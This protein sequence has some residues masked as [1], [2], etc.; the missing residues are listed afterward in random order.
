[1]L[2]AG[3]QA[4]SG[5]VNGW[6]ALAAATA[7]SLIPDLVWFHLGRAYGTRV[8]GFLCRL[9]L[10]PDSCSRRMQNLFSRFGLRGLLVAKFVPGLSTLAPPL[11]GN[12]RVGVP[13]FIAV[14]GASSVL[15]GGVYLGLGFMFSQQLDQVMQA[16]AGLG[17]GAFV[18]IAVLVASYLGYKYHLRQRFLRQHR[19]ARISVDELHRLQEAGQEVVVLD[20][21]AQ[22]EFIKDAALIRG[23]I[24][25]TPDDV[26]HRHQ[27]IPRDR[28]VILYCSCPNEVTSARIALFLHRKGITRVR[29]LLGGI[30]A[31][32]ERGYPTGMLH[33][34]G[35]GTLPK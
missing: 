23:A 34:D 10:E 1:L 28:D 29:P 12:A 19:M 27:E 33:G 21:R 20:L 24:H 16:L 35:A 26:E 7:G 30:D 15:Y 22:F 6:L 17:D 3:A 4:R 9:T 8:L 11:A 25:M 32:R 5:H 31:W 13:L 18:G 2:V 14:D